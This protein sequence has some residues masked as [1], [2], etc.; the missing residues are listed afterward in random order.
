MHSGTM[1]LEPLLGRWFLSPFRELTMK[2]ARRKAV[3]LA[4][5]TSAVALV[6]PSVQAGVYT[7]NKTTTGLDWTTAANWTPTAPATG[8]PNNPGDVA[9]VNSNITANITLN[10]N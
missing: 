5:L 9:N 8:I 1:G 2:N 6:A 4:A 3:R 7:F 10:V